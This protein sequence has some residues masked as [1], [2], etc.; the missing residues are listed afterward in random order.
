MVG[1][2]SRASAR[3]RQSKDCRLARSIAPADSI[4]ARIRVGECCWIPARC[5]APVA[6][7]W[8]RC[9]SA[10][11]RHPAPRPKPRPPASVGTI[12]PSR[13]C[14]SAKRS[15]TRPPGCA[16]P[17]SKRCNSAR[18]MALIT[19]PGAAIQV[20]SGPR[21]KSGDRRRSWMTTGMPSAVRPTSISKVVTPTASALRKPG[22]VFSGA[23]PRAP[24]C[25]CASK[26][27][28]ATVAALGGTKKRPAPTAVSS[29]VRDERG[30]GRARE[31]PAAFGFFTGTLWRGH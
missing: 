30:P 16:R 12:T 25:P 20:P 28:G 19:G 9:C 17:T 31:L 1:A 21:A 29:K 4:S 10:R 13:P 23:K 2:R 3:L 7:S 6:K 5:R 18:V 22:K 26:L 14:C 27:D 8:S 24:R 15:A 11:S